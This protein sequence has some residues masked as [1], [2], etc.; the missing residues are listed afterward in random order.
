MALIIYLAN[1]NKTKQIIFLVKHK[2]NLIIC[3]SNNNKQIYS[4]SQISSS[5]C[6]CLINRQTTLIC[7]QM[8][9]LQIIYLLSNRI[10]LE[11][12]KQICSI[13]R[14]C[15]RI[16]PRCWCNRWWIIISIINNK[17]CLMVA[18]WWIWTWITRWCTIISNSLIF[19][20]KW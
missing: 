7:S 11:I 20:P 2:H 5:L 13:I 15:T 12:P 18:E 8:L 6:L 16:N 4:T 19:R 14:I 9:P 10:C 17:W 3:F 1:S